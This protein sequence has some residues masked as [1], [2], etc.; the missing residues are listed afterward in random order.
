MSRAKKNVIPYSFS[1]IRPCEPRINFL[2]SFIHKASA[3][4]STKDQKTG[5]VKKALI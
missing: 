2:Y 1:I 4:T 5:F 3:Y